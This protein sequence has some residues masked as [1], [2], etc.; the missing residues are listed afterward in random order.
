M[1]SFFNTNID[2]NIETDNILYNIINTYDP[3]YIFMYGVIIVII[4]FISTKISYN[5]NILIG[6]IFCSLIIYY[7]YTFKKYNILTRTQINNE[8]F[9]LLYSKN[10][11]LYKYPKIVDFLFYMENFKSNNIQEFE[12]VVK[13]FENFCKLYEYCLIDYNLIF[14]SYRSLIDQKITILNIINNLIFTTIP[15]EYEK[16]LIKQKI[17]AEKLM[18]DLLNN[19]VL[20]YK[21]K[22]YY[23]GYNNNSFLIP[24]SNILPYNILNN[25]DY[26]EHND[27]YNVANLIFF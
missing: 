19:L 15:I 13:S 20:L 10:Q 25:L 5:S 17:A 23:D 2:T 4:T 1:E 24:S 6:L 14:T 12:R 9:N 8:K 22:I 27:N 7:L 26:K 3:Q 11:I 18:D 21:K 16:I